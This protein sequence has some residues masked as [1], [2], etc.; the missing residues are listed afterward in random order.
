MQAT[1]DEGGLADAVRAL[2]EGHH[3]KAFVIVT[4]DGK[5]ERGYAPVVIG[6][7]FLQ[8]R[9]GPTETQCRVYPLH[10]IISITPAG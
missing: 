9:S 7:D 2:L 6:S 3:S 10:A 4:A 1:R 5:Q 8:C